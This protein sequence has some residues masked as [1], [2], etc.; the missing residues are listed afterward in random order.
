MIGLSSPLLYA[1]ELTSV[2]NNACSGCNS[3]FDRGVSPAFSHKEWPE[4]LARISPYAQRIKLTGGEP[5][6]HPDFSDVVR[7]VDKSGILFTLF[8]NAR[9]RDPS[10]LIGLLKAADHFGG[11]L[12]S[13]HGPDAITHETFTQLPG[14]F[15]ETCQNI[16]RATDAGLRVHISTVL[17][18]YNYDRVQD[19]VELARSLGAQRVVFNRYIGP[20]SSDLLLPDAFQL[21]QAVLRIESLRRSASQSPQFTIRYGN[22]IPQC[23]APSSS[24]GCWAGIAFCAIDP[25]GNVRPCTHSPTIAGSILQEPIE[26]VWS[27]EIMRH[28]R[29]R[30][31][32][33]CKAC[34]ILEIC[35]G[36]C[37]AVG[38]IRD[39]DKD[40]LMSH[41]APQERPHPPPELEMHADCR[42]K[43]VCRY[44][45]EPFGYALFDG[46]VI[47]PVTASAKAI[48]DRLDGQ[49]TLQQIKNDFGQEILDFI[50]SLYVRGLVELQA[51]TP[52]RVPVASN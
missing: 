33:Q 3:V 49:L 28:W 52:L 32:S 6:L 42:P 16:Q 40:P 18:R 5:T 14:S 30:L 13:L 35:H 23:F 25:W 15:E 21:H 44:R 45:P 10:R 11:A 38:E 19:V 26:T 50:G 8:S 1:V 47:V 27:S 4:I 2:C 37:K 31:S 46:N 43:L 7:S 22:C 9:W 36:G 34:P 39:V 29:L 12:V 24:T 17:T 51:T 48:L 41:L 20:T